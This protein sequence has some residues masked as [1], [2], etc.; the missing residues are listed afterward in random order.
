MLTL[1]AARSLPFE[2]LDLVFLLPKFQLE[3]HNVQLALGP[4]QAFFE[5]YL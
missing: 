1:Q 3:L 4:F 2:L 5:F